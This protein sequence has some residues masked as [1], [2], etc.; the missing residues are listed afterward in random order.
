L[1][2]CEGAPEFPAWADR[3]LAEP[4]DAERSCG[5]GVETG[6]GV[7][8]A[9]GGVGVGSDSA[10]SSLLPTAGATC[11]VVGEGLAVADGSGVAEGDGVGVGSGVWPATGVADG[12][13]IRVAV[14]RGVRLGG[15]VAVGRR[16]AVALG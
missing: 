5:V 11:V 16:I 7:E 13:A 4:R 9:S 1:P 14:G 15:G 3:R 6:A 10:R 8:P 2:P 12:G